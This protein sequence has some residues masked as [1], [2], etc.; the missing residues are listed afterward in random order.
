MAPKDADMPAGHGL[1]EDAHDIAE[2]IQFI[3][4][5]IEKL[6]GVVANA[7]GHQF[8]RAKSAAS[9]A[10]FEFEAAVRRNPLPAIAIAAGIGFLYGVL[11]RR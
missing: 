2:H 11:T 6:A 8:D 5:D 9:E 7:G 4:N 3:R 10:A 1:S